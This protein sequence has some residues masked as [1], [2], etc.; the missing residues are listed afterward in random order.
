MQNKNKNQILVLNQIFNLQGGEWKRTIMMWFLRFFYRLGFVIGWT[1]ILVAFVSKFGIAYL[2][3]LFALN[4]FFIILGT[5]FYSLL[6]PHFKKYNIMLLTVALSASLLLILSKYFF[7]N[8]GIF[9]STLL[10]IEAVLMMQFKILMDGYI[11]E[12]FTPLQSERIFPLIEA[13]ETIGGICA[14]IIM[15]SFSK[16]FATNQFVLLWGFFSLSLVPVLI[17]AEMLFGKFKEE[18]MIEKEVKKNIFIKMKD[19]FFVNKTSYFLKG[20]FFVV[21]FHWI[22]FNLLEFQY[23]LAVYKSAS[24]VVLEGGSGFEHAFV[25]DLGGLFIIFSVS[26]LIIQFIVGSRLINSL[27]IISSML[28]HPIVTFLSSVLLFINNGFYLAILTKNNFTMTSAIY[29]NS[30][31]SAYYAIKENLRDYTREFFEGIVRPL[32]ALLGPLVLLVLQIFFSDQNLIYAINSSLI[33]VSLIL[34]IIIY[35]QRNAYTKSALTDLFSSDKE[36][37]INALEILTQKGHDKRALENFIKILFDD[38]EPLSLKVKILKSFIEL[39][40]VQTIPHILKCLEHEKSAIREAALDSLFGYKFILKNGHSY[41]SQKFNIAQSLKEM[42]KN[43]IHDEL[44]SRIIL[45]MSYLSHISTLEFLFKIIDSKKDEKLKPEAILAL[46]NFDD[47]FIAKK[48]Y[49][50]LNSSN[51]KIKINSAISLMK[52]DDY[53]DEAMYAIDT[54]LFSDNPEKIALGLFAIGELSFSKKKQFCL[55]YIDSD[56]KDLEVHSAIALAKMGD[57]RSINKLIEL[58]FDDDHV[59]SKKVKHMIKDVDVLISKNIDRIVYGIVHKKI[60]ELNHIGLKNEKMYED[61]K[62]LYCLAEE[63]D[64]L[65]SLENNKL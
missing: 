3:L 17:I 30:Y 5:F 42:Y 33:L 15:I 11:E 31:H 46:N 23:T 9:F 50:F 56:C 45:I 60:K 32:G 58:L 16:V 10:F 13:A 37:R 25:H 34:I 24:N 6:L 62:L 54:F 38:K 1:I 7:N 63:F 27:G 41:L 53:K 20:L 55:K 28:I 8:F 48:I 52:Y 14:G 29:T 65:E 35:K 59:L 49:P 51:L 26:A 57:K 4:A 43:E 61:I 44:R 2:P 47:I 18:E 36:D 22:L 39:N 64:E 40:D 12:M 21:L 19:E